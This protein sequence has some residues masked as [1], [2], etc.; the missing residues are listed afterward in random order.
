MFQHHQLCRGGDP[1]HVIRTLILI[2]FLA[3]TALI[4]PH[5]ASAATRVPAHPMGPIWA[6]IIHTATAANISGSSTFLYEIVGI[7][8]FVINVTPSWDPDGN[9]GCIDDS[10]PLGVWF[11]GTN[12]AIF[13]ED[14]TPMVPGTTYNISFVPPNRSG[15]GFDDFSVTTTAANSVGGWTILNDLSLNGNPNAV[16]VVT[17]NYDAGGVCGCVVNN[18]NIG[19]LYLGNVW[20]IMNEDNT[21]IPLGAQFNV[22]VSTQRDT[23]NAWSTPPM[24]SSSSTDFLNDSRL[25]GHPEHVLFVTPVW[26]PNWTCGC[27]ADTHPLGVYY[28]EVLHEWS[29]YNEDYAPIPTG[30]IFNVIALDQDV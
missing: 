26:N 16:I 10:H 20:V 3:V 14:G 23:D 13:H 21:P 7:A 5:A 1:R 24:A 12:W 4:T 25:N 15:G 30:M 18:H 29:I 8:D 6:R 27:V 2:S 17:Q 11:N 19:V 9:C 22:L 28:A